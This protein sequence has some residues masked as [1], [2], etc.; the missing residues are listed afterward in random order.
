MLLAITRG[1]SPAIGRCELTHFARQPIDPRLASEQHEQYERS[2]AE[3]GC[4]VRRLP[5]DPS[6]PDS[7]FVED[8]AVVVDELAVLTRPGAESRR[9]EVDSIGEAL[10]PWRRL[11]RIAAPGT[12]DGGDVLRMD[13]RIFVGRSGR[14]NRDGID[15][16]RRLLEPEGYEV[17]EVEVAGA[18]HLKSA[19]TCV[20]DR[21]VLINRHLLDPSP[22]SSLRRIEVDP[23]EP[24]GA[25]ALRVGS[26]LLYSASFP[27]T[28]R[29]LRDHGLSPGLLPTSELGK[30][31][32]GLTCCSLLFETEAAS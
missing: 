10:A 27:R 3:M 24:W 23:C 17:I 7:V 31:E 22:F 12:L 9:P 25:N 1:V 28:A 2:R 15:Q 29:R 20:D 6:L 4:E 5:E 16:L 26:G 30:A 32:G 8:A 11:E 19:V 21:T 14:S 18:L 13:R